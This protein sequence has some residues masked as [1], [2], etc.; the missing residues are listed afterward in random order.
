VGLCV[1]LAVAA[2]VF[3]GPP[4]AAIVVVALAVGLVVAGL[5][6]VGVTPVLH[7]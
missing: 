1:A 4:V 5:L 3:V 2:T 7:F 6:V